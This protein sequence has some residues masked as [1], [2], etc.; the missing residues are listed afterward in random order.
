MQILR[1]KQESQGDSIAALHFPDAG[2]GIANICSNGRSLWFFNLVV[3]YSKDS[4]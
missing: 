4:E 1:G 3:D 2:T